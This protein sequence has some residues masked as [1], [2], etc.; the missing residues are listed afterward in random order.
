MSYKKDRN[1][2]KMILYYH[3]CVTNHS[4]YRI[5]SDNVGISAQQDVQITKKSDKMIQ[6]FAKILVT[7]SAVVAVAGVID[8]LIQLRKNDKP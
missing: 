3:L 2:T 8:I 4:L 1:V 5:F 6:I 7:F